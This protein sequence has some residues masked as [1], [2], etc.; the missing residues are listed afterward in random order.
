[1]TV[2]HTRKLI[3]LSSKSC[4]NVGELSFSLF[5]WMATDFSRKL[6]DFSSHVLHQ[7]HDVPGIILHVVRIRRDTRLQNWV[8]MMELLFDIL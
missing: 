2:T 1:M 4:K 5:Y 8:E 6:S 7:S 3:L